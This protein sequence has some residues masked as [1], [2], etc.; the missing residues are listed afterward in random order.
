MQN[1]TISELY[2]DD[3]KSKSVSNTKD[4]LTS[5]KKF[6]DKLYTK[7]NVSE[8]AMNDLLAKIPNHKKISNEHFKLCEA[9]ISL[10]EVTEAIKSQKQNKSPGSD[11]LSAEFYKHFANELA[12]FLLDVFKSWKKLGVIGISSRTGIISVIYKKGDKK[13]ITNYRPISPLN[14]DY[15]IY[16]SILKNRMQK[17][18]HKIISENQ[19]AAIKN[20]TILHTLST[21]HDIID[22]SNTLNKN[23][24]VISLDFLKAFDRID[25]EFVFLTLQKF[26]YG[27]NFIQMI[28]VA[29]NNIQSRI[30]INGFLSDLFTLMRG[31]RQGCPLSMLLYIVAAEV[32]ANFIIADTKIKGIQ[33][34]S[35]EIKIVNFA[36]DTTIF[37]RDINCLDRIQTILE[38]Y[39][40][41]S[42]S[43]INLSKSHALWAGEYKNRYDQPGNMEWSSLSI[44]I[45][46]INFGNV[47]LANSIWDK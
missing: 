32:L 33:I 30:K 47:N 22:V 41:A 40:T 20:R 21:I 46:G 9:E 16:T 14:L 8:S 4:I 45:L 7:E 17:T 27:N 31:V 10:D 24:S 26:R 38:L 12:P 19:T 6:Y 29:Y 25:H 23:L 28:K 39:E 15:K 42:S 18:L 37:L 34:G 1:Q 5:A 43:K 44:K 3:K 2:V 11:G 13:D 36:D 35:H